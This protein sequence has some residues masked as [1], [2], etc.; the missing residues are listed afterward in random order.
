M[1]PLLTIEQAEKM[2]NI[3]TAE[4]HFCAPFQYRERNLTMKDLM[5]RVGSST[6]PRPDT[7]WS[8]AVNVK[9]ITSI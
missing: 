1:Q 9:L 2:Q 6:L 7:R 4:S 8:G 3:V 5:Q